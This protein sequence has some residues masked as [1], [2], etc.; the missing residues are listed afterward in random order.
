MSFQVI[1]E[2]VLLIKEK[3]INLSRF[4]LTTIYDI[5]L[6]ILKEIEMSEPCREFRADILFLISLYLV[7]IPILAH[8]V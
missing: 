8:M 7:N 3:N 2:F 1:T 6:L 5:L 4:A